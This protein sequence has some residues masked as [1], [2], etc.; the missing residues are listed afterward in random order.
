MRKQFRERLEKLATHLESGKLGHAK[1]DFSA[2]NETRDHAIPPCGKC[3]YAGC[4][5]GELPIVF[6]RL[7]KFGAYGHT[8]LRSPR[9]MRAQNS[10][11]SF[12]HSEEF[13]GL[14]CGESLGLFSGCN[15][16]PWAKTDLRPDATRKQVARGIRMFLRWK[17]IAGAAK[18]Q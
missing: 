14:T 13:F 10:G 12:S 4:A 11:D 17:K 3:G 15:P 6:P 2:I 7:W 5:L 9:T 8:V 1:F 16:R 18:G